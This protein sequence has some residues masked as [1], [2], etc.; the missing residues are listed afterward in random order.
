MFLEVGMTWLKDPY[1]RLFT[2]SFHPA[3]VSQA[4]EVQ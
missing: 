3:N 1:G 2:G 4:L